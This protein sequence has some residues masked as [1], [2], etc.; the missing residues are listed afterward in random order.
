MSLDIIKNLFIT[1][2]FTIILFVSA[3]SIYLVKSNYYKTIGLIEESTCT[4]ISNSNLYSCD[5]R[6]SYIIKGNQITNQLVINSNIKYKVGDTINIEYDIN[7]YLNISLQSEYKQIA[8]ISTVSGLIFMM[9]TIILY[10]EIKKDIAEL[11]SYI[12]S[13]N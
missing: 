3:S 8:L 2:C 1:F 11:L 13:F 9:I 5:L 6:I 4:S 12:P 7:N 10:N